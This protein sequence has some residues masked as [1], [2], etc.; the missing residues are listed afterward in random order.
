M[1]GVVRNMGH[2]HPG[3]LDASTVAELRQN[4]FADAHRFGADKDKW[5]VDKHPLNMVRLP[6][7]HRLFPNARVIL[8]ER[9]PY[10]VVLSTFM[11]NFNLNHAMRSFTD[12]DE[13]AHTY[14]AAFSSW[15]RA[16][17]LFPIDWMS[18][19]Y[20]TLVEDPRKELEPLIDWLGLDWDDRVLAHTE[21]A[22]GRV[23]TASYSQIGEE[24]YTRATGRWQR[25]DEQLRP[26]MPILKP[27][28]DKMGYADT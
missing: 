27:W 16:T 19:R 9:H 12:L 5:I 7:I 18:V 17:E 24:L 15:T 6:T 2:R 4:Y 13:A 14:D 21:T 26:V 28:A 23:R 11:A 8:A 10:D 22:R 25:Y 3:H 1:A 20:E